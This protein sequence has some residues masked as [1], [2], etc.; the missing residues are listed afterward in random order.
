MAFASRINRLFGMKSRLSGSSRRAVAAREQARRRRTALHLESLED[1]VMLTSVTL[2]VNTVNDVPLGTLLP[3]LGWDTN[4]NGEISLRSALGAVNYYGA[5]N[6][7]TLS[8]ITID[9]PS[10]VPATPY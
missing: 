2:Q 4:D 5:E 3:T 1:R 8:S 10:G 7:G 6:H 9:V